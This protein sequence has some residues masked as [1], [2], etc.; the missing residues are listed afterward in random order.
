[1]SAHDRRI[2]GSVVYLARHGETD[3]NTAGRWQGHTDV[4]INAN[5]RAQAL[6]LGATLRDQKIAAIA[7]SDL[8][9]ARETATI[10]GS[11][12]GV[13]VSVID[14]GLRERRFGRFEGLTR[15]ECAERYPIEWARYHADPRTAPPDGEPQSSLVERASAAVIR[16]ASALATP[17]LVVTHGGT[18]RALLGAISGEPVAP[19]ANGAIHAIRVAEGRLIGSVAWRRTD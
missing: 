15:A 17:I 19:V 1:M 11:V 9:R 14:S 2:M 18:M 7:S 3:W 6:A 10:A 16:I 4:P 13:D 12:L 8:S 5:G